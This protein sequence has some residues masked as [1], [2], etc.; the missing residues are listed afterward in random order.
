MAGYGYNGRTIELGDR[1]KYGMNL[2]VIRVA[3]I[4][5]VRVVV[6]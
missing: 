1:F 3:G 4:E 2:E 6:V 5:R